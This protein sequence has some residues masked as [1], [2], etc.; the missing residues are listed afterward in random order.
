MQQQNFPGIETFP[1]PVPDGKY[2]RQGLKKI[3]AM[4]A[5]HGAVANLQCGGCRNLISAPGNTINVHKCKMYGV[6]K[7]S[8][9]DWRKKWA[10]CGLFL[11]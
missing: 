1:N 11:P 6:S 3:A 4:H 8:A 5:E 2:M 10:A 7:S 9:T